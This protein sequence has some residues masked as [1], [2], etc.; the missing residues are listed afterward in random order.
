MAAKKIRV[1]DWPVQ[2]PDPNPKESVQAVVDRKIDIYEKTFSRTL[3][4]LCG[5]V[6]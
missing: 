3:T 2:S 1:M 5:T 4:F 6:I